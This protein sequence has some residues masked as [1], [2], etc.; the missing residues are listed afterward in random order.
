MNSAIDS[1]GWVKGCQSAEARVE[2]LCQTMTK[3]S[4]TGIQSVN[5]FSFE[6]TGLRVWKSCGVGPGKLITHS[7]LKRHGT[8]QEPTGLVILKPFDEPR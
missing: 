3:H 8:P 4:K 7:Q 5:N 1:Y 6:S 2:E